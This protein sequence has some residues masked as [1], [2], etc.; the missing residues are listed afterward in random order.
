MSKPTGCLIVVFDPSG[1]TQPPSRTTARDP[2]IISARLDIPP[3]TDRQ[4]LR[5]LAEQLVALLMET[6]ETTS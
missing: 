4:V 5:G 1:K 6:M 2:N 3:Y